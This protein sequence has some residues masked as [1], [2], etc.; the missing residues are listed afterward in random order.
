MAYILNQYRACG[1]IKIKVG[2]ILPSDRNMSKGGS[3]MTHMARVSLVVC[4]LV[5]II[6]IGGVA[7]AQ[8]ADD[9]RRIVTFLG[10]DLTD[11]G[12]LATAVW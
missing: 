4:G 5:S 1:Q 2:Q 11:P 12:G 10:L 9:L 6:L 8:S 7:F 3:P